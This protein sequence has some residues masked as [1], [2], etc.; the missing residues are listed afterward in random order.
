MIAA[1]NREEN[2]LHA[3][4]RKNRR[5]EEL[6]IAEAM[7]RLANHQLNAATKGSTP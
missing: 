5:T 3:N 2:A 6:L 7:V 4:A 1:T